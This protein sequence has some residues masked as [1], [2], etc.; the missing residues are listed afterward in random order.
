MRRP[1]KKIQ[2]GTGGAEYE[3]FTTTFDIILYEI[4]MELNYIVMVILQFQSENCKTRS[5]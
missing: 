2:E 3:I 4:I 5:N 1:P